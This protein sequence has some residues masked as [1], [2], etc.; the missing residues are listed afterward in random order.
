MSKEVIEVSLVIP[1]Y[2]EVESVAE[3]YDWCT[4]VLNEHKLSYEGILVD[5]GSDDGSWDVSRTCLGGQAVSSTQETPRDGIPDSTFRN[6]SKS[7]FKLRSKP[8]FRFKPRFK[9]RL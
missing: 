4:R 9:P 1:V 6:A 7:R 3:L 2:N 8:W 5:D